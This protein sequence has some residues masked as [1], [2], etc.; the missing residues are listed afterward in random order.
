MVEGFVMTSFKTTVV[1]GAQSD[2]VLRGQEH[3]ESLTNTLRRAQNTWQSRSDC[4]LN[5]EALSSITPNKLYVSASIEETHAVI[6]C[7]WPEKRTIGV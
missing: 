5:G 3:E 4:D 6:F 1:R 2:I 7:L